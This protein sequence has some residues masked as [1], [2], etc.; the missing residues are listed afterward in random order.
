MSS[1]THKTHK[2]HKT[3]SWTARLSRCGDHDG[4]DDCD[5]DSSSESSSS[6]R[7]SDWRAEHTTAAEETGLHA[8]LSSLATADLKQLAAM[9]GIANRAKLTSISKLVEA[10]ERDVARVRPLSRSMD[11]LADAVQFSDTSSFY[12]MENAL[13][14][15][16]CH[17]GQR[18]LFFATMEFL[19][20]MTK[21]IRL[22]EALVVYV[23]AAP[24]YNMRIICELFPCASFLLIDPAPFDIKETDN[25]RIWSRMFTDESV[26]DI[27]KYRERVVARRH[28]LFVSDIRMSASEEDIGR[29]M[30]SQQ[31]WGVQLRASAML[32]KF[33]LPYYGT[34]IAEQLAR[35]SQHVL[36]ERGVADAVELRGA[37]G[38]R[39]AA[40]GAHSFLYLDGTVLTQ[41]YAPLRSAETR[42]VVLHPSLAVAA[43]EASS[44]AKGA[45]GRADPAGKTTAMYALRY[46][47]YRKYE[48]KMNAFNIVCRSLLPYSVT[49]ADASDSTRL[50]E[51]LLGYGNDYESVAEYAMVREYLAWH[52]QQPES[53]RQ[54]P[55][56]CPSPYPAT[57]RRSGNWISPSAGTSLMHGFASKAT[58]TRPQLEH[59]VRF[60]HRLNMRLVHH[61]SSKVSLMLCA[62]KTMASHTRKY[63]ELSDCQRH[64][65]L[66]MVSTSVLKRFE[67]Q[68]KIVQAG[69]VL[70][71]REKQEMI[72]C[73][74]KELEMLSREDADDD[75][76]AARLKCG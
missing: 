73:I 17:H 44:S 48:A 45:K 4:G 27:Q 42:L 70:T 1:Q 13:A 30:A 6:S 22:S 43:G 3:H 16:N 66:R 53:P 51:H 29:D 71:L 52:R 67:K 26:E 34:R 25:L 18:K 32:L 9:L 39:G 69:D 2:T 58:A 74:A 41:L 24:G 23:G 36:S 56:S 49:G 21:H 46:W 68:M 63:N 20:L 57:G 61:Y 19:T 10:I 14:S 40:G 8:R 75:A 47:D 64:A 15:Y 33:R 76:A 37:G 5:E 11:D 50:G 31:R 65:Q 38:S 12:R 54:Q 59:V 28:L 60:L 72:D 7:S 35:D 62:V 55:Q